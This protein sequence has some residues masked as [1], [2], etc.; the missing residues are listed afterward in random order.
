MGLLA[1]I[2]NDLK[3]ALKAKDQFTVGVLRLIQAGLQNKEIEERAKYKEFVITDEIVELVLRQEAKKRKDAIDVFR[4]GGRED[5]AKKEEQE[6]DIIKK[7]LPK[8]L[9]KQ[10]VEVLVSKIVSGEDFKDFGS[11]MKAV[12]K[13]LKG[14]ADP[15]FL[16]ECVKSAF[17]K[18]Q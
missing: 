14:K 11:A 13:E 16:A 18:Q 17:E 15:R 3:T 1:T 7:Y 9:D 12:L 10:T 4:D 6:L 8:E 2:N 5:L